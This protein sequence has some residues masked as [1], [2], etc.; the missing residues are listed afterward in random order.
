MWILIAVTSLVPALVGVNCTV[1]DAQA[2]QIRTEV[3][4]AAATF[5]TSVGGLF[6]AYVSGWIKP[7]TETTT[8]SALK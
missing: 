3:A 2:E 4:P 8:T 1:N 5:L 7:V 6:G